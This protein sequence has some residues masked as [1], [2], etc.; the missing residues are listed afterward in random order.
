MKIEIEV[1]PGMWIKSA[2]PTEEGDYIVHFCDQDRIDM[3]HFTVE[4][5]WN[6]YADAY[7]HAFADERIDAWMLPPVYE[8]EKAI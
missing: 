2:K 1:K 8:P 4:H 6:T 3:I 5:G 7:A